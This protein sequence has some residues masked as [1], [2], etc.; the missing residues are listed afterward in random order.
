MAITKRPDARKAAAI[1]Q[2]IGSAPDSLA[3]AASTDAA[4]SRTQVRQKKETISLGIDP[5][6]LARVD[7][8]ATRL[9][10]SRAAA[11]ALAVS[12][13]VEGEGV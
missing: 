13:F 2:F 4:Q 7:A 8:V 12:R 3:P 6:L 10:V 1:E 5:T 11:F 9:G